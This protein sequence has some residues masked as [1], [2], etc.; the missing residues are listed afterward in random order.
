MAHSADRSTRSTGGRH[1]QPWR[2]AGVVLIALLAFAGTALVTAGLNPA[3]AQPPQPVDAA[4]AGSGPESGADPQLR[5]A[6]E[7][8]TATDRTEPTQTPT[9]TQTS[10]PGG[11]PPGA[12]PKAT[13]PPGLPRSEPVRIAIPDIKVNA[14]VVPLGLNGDGTVQVPSLKQAQ[15]AGWYKLGVSPGEI[16]NAVIVG[17]VDSAAM[18]PAVFFRLGALHRGDEVRVTRKDGVVVRFRVDAVKS[19]PKTAFPSEL[20]Y[21]TANTARLQVVTCGGTFDRKKHS[22]PNN[23]VVSATRIP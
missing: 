4:P 18:G 7:S 17:H 12:G 3:P 1:G 10:T 21:G 11:V 9:P 8:G 19:Y 13:P 15:R 16:G 23:I 5:S 2:A 20:V 22:Y 14:E 6:A